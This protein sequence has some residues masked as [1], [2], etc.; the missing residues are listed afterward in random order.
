MSQ[1]KAYFG[2]EE[3][4]A[5]YVKRM[6]D[7]IKADEL[8]RNVGFEDGKGCAVGCTLDRYSH[9]GFEDKL[10]IPE[11]VAHLIDKLHENTSDNVWPSF[12]INFL[13]A[14]KPGVN[15]DLIKP[16]LM[17]FILWRNLN[18]ILVIDISDELKEEITS[19]IRLC[20][21]AQD[22]ESKKS[23]ARSAAR[24]AESAARSAESAARS[25]ES[26]ARSA[27]AAARNARSAARSAESAARSAAWAA[28][29]ADWS[30]EFDAIAKEF[31][32]LVDNLEGGY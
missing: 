23:A 16:E 22:D 24:S 28:E 31:L 21:D 6:E 10:G 12:S 29:S 13:K 30:A 26:A 15:L 27:G 2:S 19:A 3:V 17:K 18:R 14:V 25:A 32:R 20:I 7:H 9:K 8:I 11:W 1:F 5:K 4:K